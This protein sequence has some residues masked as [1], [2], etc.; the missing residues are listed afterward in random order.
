MKLTAGDDVS[1][2]GFDDYPWMSARRTPLTAVRQPIKSIA[3]SAWDR[4]T[5]RMNGLDEPPM[6]IVHS[7]SLQKRGSTRPP[8]DEPSGDKTRRRSTGPGKDGPDQADS[9]SE[10]AKRVH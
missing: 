10:G 2:V 7:C 6:R 9:P 1:L 5:A 3:D 8:K 4:L